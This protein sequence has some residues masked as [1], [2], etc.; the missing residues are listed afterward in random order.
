MFYIYILAV[1]FELMY[2]YYEGLCQ[3]WIS[4]GD[5]GD[6]FHRKRIGEWIGMAGYIHILLGVIILA[7]GDW[8]FLI[9]LYLTIG[10]GLPLYEFVM[11]KKK[12]G[13]YFAEKTGYWLWIKQPRVSFWKKM[14]IISSLI[15]IATLIIMGV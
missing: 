10:V 11:R 15:L 4:S 3:S 12:Y 6:K 2:F 1:F 13:S 9:L 8:N 7:T 5:E 14:F